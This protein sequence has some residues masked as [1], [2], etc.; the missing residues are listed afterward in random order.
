MND[1]A[2]IRPIKNG[3]GSGICSTKDYTSEYSIGQW[4]NKEENLMKIKL[5]LGYTDLIFFPL[6]DI[7]KHQICM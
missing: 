5:F 4:R 2:D 6:S 7:F 1:T 3:S